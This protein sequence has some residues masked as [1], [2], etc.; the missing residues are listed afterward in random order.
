MDVDELNQS[1]EHKANKKKMK[2]QMTTEETMEEL[3]AKIEARGKK[4]VL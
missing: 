1:S 2:H 4:V 3:I